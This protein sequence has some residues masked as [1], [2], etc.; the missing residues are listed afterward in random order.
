MAALDALDAR[1]DTHP[2]SLRGPL[3]R[4]HVGKHVYLLAPRW[5]GEGFPED[6]RR[7]LDDVRR[8]KAPSRELAVLAAHAM[9]PGGRR[10]AEE[11]GVGWTDEL[12]NAR[13]V[14]P[15]ALAVVRERAD[16]PRA[17]AAGSGWSTS[18]GAV[19][20]LLLTRRA[21]HDEEI[22]PSVAEVA[23]WLDWSAAQVAKV[24]AY[25][26][27]QGWTAKEG[28]QRGPTARRRLVDPSGLLS[29]WAAWHRSRP[30]QSQGYSA[31]VRDPLDFVRDHVT[32][33]L[34][35]G[36]WCVTGWLA[37]E[38]KAPFATA[39]PAIDV[40][41]EDSVFDHGARE[42]FG[43][44]ELRPVERGARVR[45]VRA[46]RHVLTLA[47]RSPVPTASPVR[48]Y[49]DLLMAGSRGEHVAEHLRETRLGF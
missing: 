4:V 41:V 46:E 42:A 10:L 9:S 2:P 40:Y 38:I 32:G 30:Q 35:D 28:S 22:V 8:E 36:S 3:L 25:F 26:D 21:A 12:G 19:A 5:A 31:Q 34:P 39:V 37:L 43:S 44:K 18:A 15:P 17:R 24:L 29:A 16:R 7:A 1:I 49:G 23:P 48:V 47:A 14:T 20:E 13:I 6:V 45:F 11:A 33:L 27:R